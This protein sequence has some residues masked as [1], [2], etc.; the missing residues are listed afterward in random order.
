MAGRLGLLVPGVQE[1]REDPGLP[2]ALET[3]GYRMPRPIACWQIAPRCPG[4]QDPQHAIQETPMAD[5]RS[6]IG[7]FWGGSSGCSRSHGAW[8]KSPR[9]MPYRVWSRT[10]FANTP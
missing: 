7:G 9:F 6:A 5:R 3:A 8:V 2:P 10:K 4:A 1:L